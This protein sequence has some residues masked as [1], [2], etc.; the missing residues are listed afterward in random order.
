[1]PLQVCQNGMMQC[2]GQIGPR[3]EVCNG[4]DD[5]CNGIIDDGFNVGGT[6]TVMYGT[7]PSMGRLICRPDGT[8][9]T[10]N[11]PP[12]SSSPE[13]C[14]GIDNNCDGVA[15][16][17]SQ[18][19][20]CPTSAPNPTG[21]ICPTGRSCGTVAD[22]QFCY[23]PPQCGLAVGE[24]LPGHL[25]CNNGTQSCVGGTQPQ[26]EICNCL[27]DNCNGIVDDNP[28][29]E[30]D[31]CFT[32]TGP[33]GMPLSTMSPSTCRPGHKHC[34]QMGG[35]CDFACV[36][37]IGPS[38]EIC[39]GL[40]NDCDGMVD[41]GAICPL[42]YTCISGQCQP[43][44]QISEFPC[45]ADRR[46][47][48]PASG[49]ECSPPRT[50][51]VCVPN[52][53]L[54][55]NCDRATQD[56]IIQN[57]MAQ[58]R[59][60][61]PPGK[62]TAPTTCVPAT[63]QCVDCFTTGCPQGQVCVGS[64]GSCEPDPCA[65]VMCNPGEFCQGGNCLNLCANVTCPTGEVCVAGNCRMSRCEG[66]QCQPGF[67]CNPDT[68]ACVPDLC[69]LGC[70]LG[71][72]CRQ[73]DGQC[74]P[75]PCATTQCPACTECQLHFDGTPDCQHQEACTAPPSITLTSAGSGGFTCNLGGPTRAGTFP[76]WALLVA[77]AAIL[78]RRGMGGRR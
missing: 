47:V 19:W 30:G 41:N 31:S 2:Q 15:D 43:N 10:C 74:I 46:C 5:D 17:P 1:M 33:G 25:E 12:V 50:D 3:T 59:D 51:C 67:L 8:G 70:P 21:C 11:A 39:D 14:D 13:V 29:G 58:C 45:T 6:C 42:R 38:P 61:C 16:E 4:Q 55:A 65:N 54:N 48:D 34:E 69:T 20:P 62:C 32:F 60:R 37:E 72:R 63:G 35:T 53:C 26:P 66:V 78:R 57:G 36:G 27:D 23:C 7:C 24:C 64:P 56:C 71:Q 22:L 52:L 77:A 49:S 75:D 44:C 18:I 68:G 73:S 76:W 9:T 28:I 40:D